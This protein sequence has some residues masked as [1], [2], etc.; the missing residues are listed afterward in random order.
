MG[1]LRR[2]D[3]TRTVSSDL[4]T[5]GADGSGLRRLTNTR[6]QAEAYPSW[7]PSGERLAFVRH[8][9]ETVENEL[10]D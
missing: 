2:R 6:C 8:L 5:I 4:F 3:G 9:P 10:I 7:D 1:T